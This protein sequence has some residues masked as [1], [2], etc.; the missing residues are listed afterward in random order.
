M[1]ELGRIYL[2]LI[3]ARARSQLEYRASLALQIVGSA[4]LTLLDFVMILV[5]FENV[6][7]LDGWSVQEVALLYGI[8][9]ISFALTDLI[10]GHLDLFPQMIRDGTFDQILVRPLPSL[11]QVIASDFSLRRIGKVL[12]GV[13]VL[14][15]ALA[16]ADI[17]WTLGR[18]VMVPLAIVSGVLI[19]T[20][21]WIA[22]ATIAFW[23]VDAIEF[24][25]AFTYGGNFLSA[26]PITIFGRWL[27]NLVLF[28]IPIAFV[29]YFPALY[30]LDRPD[31]LGLPDGLR[32]ASPFVAVLTVLVA[33]VVWEN[34]VRHYRSAGG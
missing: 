27:R 7:E 23:I 32:Y 4:L 26:Y 3:G 28:V 15:V 18:A 8:A 25:N 21:V 1:A 34:A 11:L 17:D 2:R 19:Y 20:G 31:E 10:V 14:T 9:G 12:Q 24:V 29:A 22:L 33:R 5:L 13:A 30:I 16:A 6:P